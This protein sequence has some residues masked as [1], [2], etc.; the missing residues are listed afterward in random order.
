MKGFSFHWP[1]WLTHSRRFTHIIGH[2]SAQDK[3][4]SLAKDRRSTT[5]PRNQY[6]K[7][8]VKRIYGVRVCLWFARGTWDCVAHQLAL[9]PMTLSDFQGH[10]RVAILFESN[11]HICVQHMLRYQLK[12]SVAES[13]SDS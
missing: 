2:P 12:Q 8:M 13:L 7:V 11:S 1:G 3:E 4:S 6:R 9:F 10:S 5:V